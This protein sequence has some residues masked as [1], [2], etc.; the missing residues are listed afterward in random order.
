VELSTDRFE[1]EGVGD[2]LP[3]ALPEKPRLGL[4]SEQAIQASSELLGILGGHD[5]PA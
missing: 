5:Q 1:R 2:T 4:V 3:S